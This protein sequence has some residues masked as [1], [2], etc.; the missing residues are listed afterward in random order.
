MK[1]PDLATAHGYHDTALT[2]PVFNSMDNMTRYC[3]MLAA[4]RLLACAQAGYSE[5]ARAK[6]IVD[7]GA[8]DG[9]SAFSLGLLAKQSGGSVDALEQDINL[10]R[11]A[12]IERSGLTRR[13][14]VRLHAVDGLEWLSS[15]AQA[16]S[17][18]DLIAGCWFGPDYEG[19]LAKGLLSAAREALAPGGLLVVYSDEPTMAGVQGGFRE[20]GVRYRWLAGRTDGGLYE[21]DM[22]VVHQE[23]AVG[24]GN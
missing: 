7:F 15:Q 19:E 14:P 6:R 21:P 5:V 4:S 2:H 24:H 23:G 9:A 18:Y 11:A 1:L 16:G 8:G 10:D 22:V 13:L 20:E 3:A 12:S 17:R